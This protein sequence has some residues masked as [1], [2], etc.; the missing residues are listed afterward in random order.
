MTGF[1]L[2]SGVHDQY[3][4]MEEKITA[5]QEAQLQSTQNLSGYM[6]WSQGNTEECHFLLG[7]VMMPDQSILE[8][9]PTSSTVL[10]QKSLLY[11]NNNNNNNTNNNNFSLEG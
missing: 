3:W 1:G 11:N 2:G 10:Q 8:Q 7:N 6:L 5:T 9:S 4:H